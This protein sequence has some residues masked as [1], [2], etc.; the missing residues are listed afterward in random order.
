MLTIQQPQRMT[1]LPN[2]KEQIKEIQHHCQEAQEAIKAS[3]QCLAKETNFKPFK[4]GNP[5]WLK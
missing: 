4:V 3:Q 5:I 1:Q 2:L